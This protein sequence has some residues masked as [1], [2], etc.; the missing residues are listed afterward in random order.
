MVIRER[1]AFD[2]ARG[3][4]SRT[5]TCLPAPL[6]GADMAMIEGAWTVQSQLLCKDRR[7][8]LRCVVD[9]MRTKRSLVSP[10]P[11]VTPSWGHSGTEEQPMPP[12]LSWLHAGSSTQS[13][14]N[15]EVSA[16]AGAEAAEPILSSML[17]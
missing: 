8:S 1:S 17:E 11:C 4:S 14:W 9:G 6:A 7:G 15:H 16:T 12:I 5:G 2:Y 10:L 3:S 13:G